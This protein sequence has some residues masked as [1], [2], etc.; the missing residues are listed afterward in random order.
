MRNM[1]TLI[2][3]VDHKRLG[4]LAAKDY[5]TISALVRQAIREYLEK[6]EAPL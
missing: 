3:P 5:S 2:D 4:R 6:R 1:G